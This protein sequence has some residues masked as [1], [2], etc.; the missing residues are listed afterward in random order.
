MNPITHFLPGWTVAY[1]DV[2]FSRSE[3]AAVALAG[4]ASKRGYSP[5]EMISARSDQAFVRTLRNRFNTAGSVRVFS[6]KRCVAYVGIF[7]AS[8]LDSSFPA[9]V[10]SNSV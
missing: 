5:L 8:H 6:N 7:P 3:R 4:V 1:A 10:A 9:L 2:S